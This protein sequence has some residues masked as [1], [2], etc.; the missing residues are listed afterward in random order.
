M[1]SMPHKG[2]REQSKRTQQSDFFLQTG[3]IR[4]QTRL[5][6]TLFEDD[7][8]LLFL[9]QVMTVS[10]LTRQSLTSQSDVAG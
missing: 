5:A 10:H 7:I 1:I 9:T 4:I 3:Y 2:T 6:C 8:C